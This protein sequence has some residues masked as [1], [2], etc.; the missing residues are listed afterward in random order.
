MEYLLNE[1]IIY[2]DNQDWLYKL[3]TGKVSELDL[4]F[5]GIAMGDFSSL[6]T[7]Y[8]SYSSN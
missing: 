3:D 6:Q 4:N 2:T 7:L 5:V 1:G 8:T